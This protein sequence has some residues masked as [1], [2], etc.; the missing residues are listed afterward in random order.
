MYVPPPFAVTSEQQIWDFV[1]DNPFATLVYE[2]RGQLESAAIPV[3]FCQRNGKRYLRGH[4]AR[5]NP[6]CAKGLKP[7]RL[8]ALFN[9]GDHYVSPGWYPH[10]AQDAR[11]VPTW[12]Y[13]QVEI[14]GELHFYDDADWKLAHLR[15]FVSH[16]EQSVGGDWRIDEA[17]APFVDKLLQAIVG[18]EI[19]VDSALGKFKLSQ[20][21]PEPARREVARR[22]SERGSALAR[23]M[24]DPD[25]PSAE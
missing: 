11:V 22:L 25:T 6:M 7:L 24:A 2:N 20:N 15:D 19:R 14:R 17:P 12:N 1:R 5:N 9:G 18:V 8:L 21:Q 10:K 13:A 3:R 16:F 23:L 4:L